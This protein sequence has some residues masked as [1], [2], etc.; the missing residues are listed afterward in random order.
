MSDFTPNKLVFDTNGCVDM[1]KNIY[2][3]DLDDLSNKLAQIVIKQIWDNGNGSIVMRLDACANVRETKREITDDRILLE[4][5][6]DMEKIRS[7]KEDLY[8]RICVVLHGNMMGDSWTWRDARTMY[9]K[10]GEET[11]GKNVTNKRVHVPPDQKPRPLPAGFAQPNAMTSI[12][13]GVSQNAEKEVQKHVDNFVNN[14]NKAL[15]SLNWS[16]FIT[17][18]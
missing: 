14:I 13:E 12:V 5:G 7:T 6:I 11:Y 17:G 4:V 10:P 8:V 15:N 16:A 1:I 2:N 9:T 3:S 18:G